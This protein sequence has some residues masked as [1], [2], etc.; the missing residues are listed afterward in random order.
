MVLND[1]KIEAGVAI[2]EGVTQTGQV[3]ELYKYVQD[4]NIQ[5]YVA[6]G[7]NGRAYHVTAGT[8]A[9]LPADKEYAVNPNYVAPENTTENSVV[10]T[11]EKTCE[12][13]GTNEEVLEEEISEEPTQEMTVIPDEKPA[14]LADVDISAEKVKEL[15]AELKETKESLVQKCKELTEVYVQLGAAESKAITIEQVITFVHAHG[16]ELII[17]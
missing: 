4:N 13:L 3:M 8:V 7:V 1:I 6:Y 2:L 16:Y 17:K 5:Y 9:G 12:T 11:T 15:E 14:V 10:K